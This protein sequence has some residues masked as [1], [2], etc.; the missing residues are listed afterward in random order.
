MTKTENNPDLLSKNK[1]STEEIPGVSETQITLN[2]IRIF[3]KYNS[4]VDW[5][6]IDEFKS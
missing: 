2:K 3:F 6:L 1:D 4:N 5:C